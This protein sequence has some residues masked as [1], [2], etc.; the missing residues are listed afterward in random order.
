MQN[1]SEDNSGPKLTQL[2][3]IM[4]KMGEETWVSRAFACL[5]AVS[6]DK[7][8]GGHES[9][10]PWDR[11]RDLAEEERSSASKELFEAS[12]ITICFPEESND[13]FGS[14]DLTV[15][16]GEEGRCATPVVSKPLDEQ[17]SFALADFTDA[18]RMSPEGSKS[19]SPTNLCPNVR[20]YAGAGNTSGGSSSCFGLSLQGK[21]GSAVTV[22]K[23]DEQRDESEKIVLESDEKGDCQRPHDSVRVMHLSPSITDVC[24][25]DDVSLQ[26]CFLQ[27]PQ[28]IQYQVDSGSSHG[29]LLRQSSTAPSPPRSPRHVVGEPSPCHDI[30][31]PSPCHNIGE[32]SPRHDICESSPRHDIGEPSPCHDIG[33]PSPLH[34]VGD[35]SPLHVVG[36]PSPRHVVGDPSPRHVVGEP[37]P[38]HDVGEPSPRHDVGEP[39][40]RHDVGEPSP[41]HDVGEPSPRHDVGEPSP[42]H[43]VGE[44]SPRHDVGEPSPRHDVG[45]LSPRH[46]VG[47]PSPRHV[48]GEPSPRHVVCEPSPRHIVGEPSPRQLLCMAPLKQ[49]SP[50]QSFRSPSQKSSDKPPV[51]SPRPL[52]S[53]HASCGLSCPPSSCNGG[54]TL[55]VSSAPPRIQR[56]LEPRNLECRV[57]MMKKHHDGSL[58]RYTYAPPSVELCETV[59]SMRLP[60]SLRL[61]AQSAF[62]QEETTKHDQEACDLI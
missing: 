53:S 17:A 15:S 2:L 8:G 19:L 22:Q 31:E 18:S 25:E 59:C 33:E 51:Q 48:V 16:D 57:E 47:E 56:R 60:G 58:F 40:P 10:T 1:K 4:D 45:E 13:G 11:A 54:T 24:L 39:S 32:P 49:L 29:P 38:R 7:R 27:T 5:N 44:P 42:R 20:P 52:L 14:A 30:G 23:D 37:S 28:V 6:D 21:R 46:V 9:R 62:H 43:D 55:S 35:P 61:W 3:N 34:V 36:D 12:S 26:F 50:H 41:R